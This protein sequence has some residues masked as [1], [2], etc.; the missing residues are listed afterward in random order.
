MPLWAS[1]ATILPDVH[2]LASAKFLCLWFVRLWHSLGH[3]QSDNRCLLA[4][5]YGRLH[6][7]EF[8]GRTLMILIL[9]NQ[10]DFVTLSVVKIPPLAQPSLF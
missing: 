5:E 10:A 6:G 9:T 3:P 2:H 8:L 7:R 4:K 1:D